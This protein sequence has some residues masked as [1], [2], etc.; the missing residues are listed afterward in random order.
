MRNFQASPRDREEEA[1]DAMRQL[2]SGD[3]RDE[4]KRKTE[5]V[6]NEIQRMERKIEKMT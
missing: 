3:E 5:E 4:K 1:K 2:E 6:D